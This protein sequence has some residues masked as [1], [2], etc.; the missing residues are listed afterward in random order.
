MSNNGSTMMVVAL[1]GL[2]LCCC[3]STVGVI[4]AYYMN[5]SFKG[6]VDKTLGFG[7]SDEDIIKEFVEKGCRIASTKWDGANKKA[8]CP[9]P[10]PERTIVQGNANKNNRAN[11]NLPMTGSNAP[12]L[13]LW[14]AQCV[15]NT[16]CRDIINKTKLNK[17]YP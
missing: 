10:Y 2:V 5:D 3:L 11:P 14:Q 7:K 16:E 8:T 13:K 9:G 1:G 17:D 12:Y 6:W 4:A 15:Q